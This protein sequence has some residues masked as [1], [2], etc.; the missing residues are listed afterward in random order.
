MAAFFVCAVLFLS[1]NASAS[2]IGIRYNI[3]LLILVYP[4]A[5]I[6]RECKY[7]ITVE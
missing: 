4:K 6:T 7:K 2:C 1:I 3:A 5:V